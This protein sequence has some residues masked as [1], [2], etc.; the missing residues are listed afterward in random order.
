MIIKG[1]DS[2][3]IRETAYKMVFKPWMT[4]LELEERRRVEDVSKFCVTALRV[5]LRGMFPIVDAIE[6]CMG[7]IIKAILPQPDAW[8]PKL[9]NMKFELVLEAE[10]AFKP[11]LPLRLDDGETVNIELAC[12]HTPWCDKCRWWFHTATDGCPK[13]EQQDD[14]QGS[15]P[16]AADNFSSRNRQEP[17]QGAFGGIHDAAKDPP[18]EIPARMV[19]ESSARAASGF[20]P[21]QATSAARHPRVSGEGQSGGQGISIGRNMAT[22]IHQ[23]HHAPFQGWNTGGPSP[24]GQ[25]GTWQPPD[26]QAWH[27]VI[28]EAASQITVDVLA[29]NSGCPGTRGANNGAG[30]SGGRTEVRELA[31]IPKG[32]LIGRE[33]RTETEHLLGE[34]KVRGDGIRRGDQ[35]MMVGGDRAL[36]VHHS[37]VE[38]DQD[39]EDEED[40]EGS[41]RGIHE[42]APSRERGGLQMEDNLLLPFVCTLQGN[43]IFVL[44]LWSVEDKY[45]IPACHVVEIPSHQFVIMKV[46]QLFAERFVFR[47]FP[48]DPPARLVVD[49][50][51]GC[52]ARFP[53]P[54]IDARIPP[55][56]W[57]NI[58]SVLLTD[59]LRCL[60]AE[61]RTKL[62]DEAYVEQHIFDTFSKKALDI[63][64]KLRSAHQASHDGRKRL[65]QDLKKKGQLMF[66]DH[67]GQTTK[68]EDFPDLGEV[69]EHDGASE[70]SDGGVVTPIKEKAR[71]TRKKKVVRSTGQGDQGTPAWVK[72][73]LEYEVWRDRVARGT[74]M[75]CG[76]YGHTSRTCRGKKVLTRVASPTVVGLSSNSGGASASTS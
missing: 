25:G 65:P 62:V 70:T 60:P 7:R 40:D 64:A 55:D 31:I 12:K 13:L 50:P 15:Q 20:R 66:V 1:E 24:S 32:E 51:G 8:R 76:N 54:I 67:D 22:P 63:E 73:G 39:V 48:D 11:I 17:S 57:S 18:M 36:V 37:D 52:K 28:L 56:Q 46:G 74:W 9:M 29:Q 59:Y 61:V 69:T 44:G 21:Q 6:Q 10:G 42:G 34:R 45:S 23:Q 16:A 35:G 26:D 41:P 68:I 3:I 5:P 30:S 14:G 47:M 49:L 53:I 4:R 38:D 58:A 2:V 72:L 75:N 19:A 71:G 33:E 27:A 43:E